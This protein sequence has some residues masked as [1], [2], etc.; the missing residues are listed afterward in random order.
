M[1]DQHLFISLDDEGTPFRI[2]LADVQEIIRLKGHFKG[3][4]ASA[5]TVGLRRR[6][7]RLVDPESILGVRADHAS[8]IL[9]FE[10]N[11]RLHGLPVNRVDREPRETF[12]ELRL[13]DL[14]P[15]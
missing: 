4:D 3:L 7:V 9:V 10:L 1:S 13:R 5:K 15:S 6:T 2:P 12:R 11:H 8:S 14:N